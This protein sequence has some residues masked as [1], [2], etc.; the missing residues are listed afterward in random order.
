MELYFTLD[1]LLGIAKQNIEI[2]DIIENIQPYDDQIKISIKLKPLL[3]SVN[4]VIR[5]NKFA[6]NS[7]YMLIDAGNIFNTILKM[8]K[9]PDR[10]WY[11]IKLP[12]VIINVNKLITKNFKGVQIKD[13]QFN[14]NKFR[15]MTG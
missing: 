2:P 5:F 15:V 12:N 14:D 1:E 8:K 7:L 6:D 4:V 3:P 10:D 11:E 13:I 9:L